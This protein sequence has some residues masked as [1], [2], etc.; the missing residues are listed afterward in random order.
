MK[1]PKPEPGPL[2]LEPKLTP[3]QTNILK[4]LAEG[5]DH[6]EVA[7]QLGY[8]STRGVYDVLNTIFRRLA[9]PNSIAAVYKAAKLG[10]I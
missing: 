5:Y 3:L 10:L 9:V 2:I 1:R 8:P 4:L 7:A 6:Q